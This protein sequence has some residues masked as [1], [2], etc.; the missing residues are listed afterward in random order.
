MAVSELHHA[1]AAMLPER[2]PQWHAAIALGHAEG[3]QPARLLA[4]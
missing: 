2:V 1:C 4:A 3:R